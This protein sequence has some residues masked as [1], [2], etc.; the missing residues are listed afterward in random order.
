M[1]YEAIEALGG[2]APMRHLESQLKISRAVLQGLVKQ[3]LAMLLNALKASFTMR[4]QQLTLTN[5]FIVEKTP[6]RHHFCKAP[7]SAAHTLGGILRD[8]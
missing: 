7:T 1:A 8:P 4:G 6:A 3:D 5:F 2:A